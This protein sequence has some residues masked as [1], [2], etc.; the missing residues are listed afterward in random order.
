[1]ESKQRILITVAG[2][3]TFIGSATLP[4]Y[5]KADN[6]NTLDQQSPD[7]SKQKSTDP[8]IPEDVPTQSGDDVDANI[9]EEVTID[10]EEPIPE[11]L[12]LET[13][14]PV[15]VQ[16][17]VYVTREAEATSRS[18]RAG[19]VQAGIS[20]SDI[21]DIRRPNS[22]V[23]DPVADTKAIIASMGRPAVDSIA[24]QVL[25]APEDVLD[26]VKS[27]TT[28]S[29]VENIDEIDK[30]QI[31]IQQQPEARNNNIN[32][33]TVVNNDQPIATGTL[34]L[35]NGNQL[36]P[37]KLMSGVSLQSDADGT[38][39][40]STK[41]Q[42]GDSTQTTQTQQ[43]PQEPLSQQE[44]IPLV[45]SAPNNDSSD[46]ATQS[47]PITNTEQIPGGSSYSEML[48][49]LTFGSEPSSVVEL[50]NSVSINEPNGLV[51][52]SVE[53]SN[54]IN[55]LEE[56]TKPI[57]SEDLY[58]AFKR[59]GI[60]KSIADLN[61]FAPELPGTKMDGIPCVVLHWTAGLSSD[62]QQ[63]A[64]SM[65]NRDTTSNVQ[66]FL[67]QDG[68]LYLATPTLDTKAY[69]AAG[70][71][72]CF[73]IE[74]VA[75][76]ALDLT[77]QQAISAAFMVR[78]LHEE[79]GMDVHRD[80]AASL[81]AGRNQYGNLRMP[82]E[83]AAGTVMSHS[84]I[85]ES[86]RTGKVDA[87]TEFANLVYS[88]SIHSMENAAGAVFTDGIP[89][90]TSSVVQQ[91]VY[92]SQASVQPQGMSSGQD[93]TQNYSTQ[94]IE[95]N[96]G[97]VNPSGIVVIRDSALI[98]IVRDSQGSQNSGF[99]PGL[100]E[101]EAALPEQSNPIYSQ[102]IPETP[103]L[104]T[105]ELSSGIRN[106]YDRAYKDMITRRGKEY[107]DTIFGN[108]SEGSKKILQDM[109]PYEVMD[110]NKAIALRDQY[111]NMGS[112]LP[113]LLE[114]SSPLDLETIVGY[115][116]V[117]YDV[118]FNN[119]SD[120]ANIETL[121]AYICRSGTVLEPKTT[122]EKESGYSGRESGFIVENTGDNKTE[123]A[124]SV[125]PGLLQILNKHP[126]I[127][128][129]SY[130]GVRDVDANYDP[131]QAFIHGF[132][133]VKSRCDAGD[134]PFADWESINWKSDPQAV[135]H[136]IDRFSEYLGIIRS[137]GAYDNLMNQY[138]SGRLV[139]A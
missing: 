42:T 64:F 124:F 14:L 82:D 94:S 115:S 137:S 43:V 56:V 33:I 111:P 45:P 96:E 9:E 27:I 72:E 70:A 5:V 105:P 81:L 23:Q 87:T 79:Y 89:G 60:D 71:N 100:V 54:K 113:K 112:Y 138:F 7:E 49:S 116:I 37:I 88:L 41:P 107:A 90:G 2:V 80:I 125:S 48:S 139:S 132:E 78:Y 92:N 117:A 103:N 67:L 77:P 127:D 118:V 16:D 123:T 53:W 76:D 35:V 129:N 75:N 29:V 73:G 34:A 66:S 28:N 110:A 95:D 68:T 98:D 106:E 108:L 135:Q 85:E 38:Y 99:I 6:G 91:D 101:V 121:P 11:T 109:P 104:S 32:S 57:I 130:D 114:I 20:I 39:V 74:N 13:L 59:D 131:L 86:S 120:Q 44:P 62:P 69:H 102:G 133:M 26:T 19:M 128:I 8:E 119:T 15:A 17:G 3:A 83:E 31:S 25:N 126:V 65:L 1:M 122:V 12:P 30:S 136:D 22:D 10:F 63:L 21:E 55:W 61:I 40:F 50:R 52:R 18:E 93:Y 58:Q 36:V 84:E 46:G 24:E 97:F 51:K 4:N 134:S 47:L